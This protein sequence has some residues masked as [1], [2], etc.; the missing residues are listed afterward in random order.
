VELTEIL[1]QPFRK[2]R[3][4]DEAKSALLSAAAQDQESTGN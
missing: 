1:K 4:I 2:E 3:R